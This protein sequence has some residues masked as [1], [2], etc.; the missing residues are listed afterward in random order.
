MYNHDS[1][2]L[3]WIKKERKTTGRSDLLTKMKNALN[4][5]VA[6][7]IQQHIKQKCTVTISG[8]VRNA[9]IHLKIKF[10]TMTN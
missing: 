10:T 3:E 4:E 8:V 5:K 1:H 6:G 7:Q 9:R 2:D